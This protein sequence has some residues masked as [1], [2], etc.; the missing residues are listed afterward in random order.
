MNAKTLGIVPVIFCASALGWGQA[1]RMEIQK[2]ANGVFV[3]A[4]TELPG[5]LPDA[6]SVFLIGD[7]G[8]VVVVDTNLTLESARASIAA[9]RK[10]TDRP[11]RFVVNTH[12]HDDHTSGNQVYREEF[13]SAVFIAHEETREA[14][15][16]ESV[17]SREN[18]TE[19][20][21][22]VIAQMKDALAIGRSLMGKEL[23]VAE[24][25]SYGGDI[26]L[27]EQYLADT[28]KLK[29]VLPAVTLT[30]RMTLYQGRRPIEIHYLGRGHSRGEVVVYLPHEKALIAGD[31][32]SPTEPLIGDKSHVGE[33]V[34]TL[35]RLQEIPADTIVPGHGAVM[36]DRKPVVLLHDMLASMKQQTDAAVARGETLEEARKSVD[37]RTYRKAFAGEDPLLNGLFSFYVA[38]PGVAKAFQEAGNQK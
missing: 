20:A 36:R 4:H 30:D 34:A 14:L 27:A 13:P 11:V 22:Q 2:I 9:L 23:S 32:V 7:N 29:R 5:L 18:M 8:V 16:T 33:W 21:P 6:N 15:T 1:S 3:V 35:E 37:L 10:L 26:A 17:A 19:G 12:W 25:E 38:G 31:L 28:P 24:R